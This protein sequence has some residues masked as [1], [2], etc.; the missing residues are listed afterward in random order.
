LTETYADGDEFEVGRRHGFPLFAFQE[1]LSEWW[2]ALLGS[3]A[4]HAEG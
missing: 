4:R 1:R 2:Q 3:L